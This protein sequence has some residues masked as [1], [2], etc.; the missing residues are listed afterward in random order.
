M[1]VMAILPTGFWYARSIY[2]GRYAICAITPER[3][4]EVGHAIFRTNSP[5]G[6]DTNEVNRF[7]SMILP[8]CMICVTL[9]T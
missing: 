8:L 2:I 9:C 3:I 4:R 7:L 1:L 5:Y 6:I